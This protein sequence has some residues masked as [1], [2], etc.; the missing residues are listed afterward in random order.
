MDKQDEQ[1]FEGL[2][3]FSEYMKAIAYDPQN[4]DRPVGI[5]CMVVAHV[6]DAVLNAAEH[7]KA[8]AKK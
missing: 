7:I 3:H 6:A 4:K 8:D 2:K 1:L 5:G